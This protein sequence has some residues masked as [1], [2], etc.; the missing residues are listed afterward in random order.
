MVIITIFTIRYPDYTAPSKF[1]QNNRPPMPTHKAKVLVPTWSPPGSCRPQ[2]GPTWALWTLLSGNA[3]L[4]FPCTLHGA[5]QE[6]DTLHIDLCV[7]LSKSVAIVPNIA[8]LCGALLYRAVS[9]E[10]DKLYA[11][12]VNVGHIRDK[13]RNIYFVCRFRSFIL[14]NWWYPSVLS[15]TCVV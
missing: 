2:I 7:H 11:I 14:Y 1:N 9:T 10:V 8:I 3:I 5:E 4:L 12:I 6:A 15:G 13:K